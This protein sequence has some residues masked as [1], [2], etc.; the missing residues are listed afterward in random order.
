MKLI[1]IGMVLVCTTVF[2]LSA[3]TAA[4]TTITD[5]TGDVWHWSQT[6]TT[7]AWSGNVVSKPNI[8]IIQLTANEIGDQLVL[9]M[10]VAGTIENTD[11]A[12]YWMYYNTTST[13]YWAFWT[14]GAGYGYGLQPNQTIPTM[15]TVTASGNTITAKFNITSIPASQ[16]FW[17]WAA[18]STGTLGSNSSEWWGDWAPNTEIPFSLPSNETGGTTTPGENTTNGGT[19][20]ET[21][22]GSQT[23]GF[24]I[25]PLI[26][27]IA[28]AVLLIRKRR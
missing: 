10:T 20:N 12:G 24:E 23:P 14:N 5:G 27:A 2:V 17:G 26:T 22:S 11:K 13:S 7:W 4:A 9:T 3:L 18:E 19:T 21:S 25:I 28:V 6:G 1:K 8:D 15:A 16:E